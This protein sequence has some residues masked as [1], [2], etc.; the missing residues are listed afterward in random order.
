MITGQCNC[1]EGAIG[2]QCMECPDTHYI[3][4]TSDQDYCME[5]FCFNH[6][7]SCTGVDGT[8]NLITISNN[9][10]TNGTHCLTND[11]VFENLKPTNCISQ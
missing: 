2:L 10:M 9:F 6:S 5:C 7:S 11:W 4:T 3:T 8:H 1:T